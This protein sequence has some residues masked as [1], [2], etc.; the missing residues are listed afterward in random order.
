VSEPTPGCPALGAPG[1]VGVTGVP[2]LAGGGD[3]GGGGTVGEV[4]AG[5]GDVEAPPALE[6]GPTVW[7]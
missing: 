6:P 5:A 2:A 7:A 1:A 4:P 3:A